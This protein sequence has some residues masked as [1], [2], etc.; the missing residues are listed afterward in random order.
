MYFPRPEIDRIFE[1][2]VFQR[3]LSTE[4]SNY[5][6]NSDKRQIKLKLMLIWKGGKIGR[7]CVHPYV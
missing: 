2:D 7:Q 5:I 3:K 4:H 1:I 6:E